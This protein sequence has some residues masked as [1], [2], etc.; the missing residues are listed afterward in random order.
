MRHVQENAVER[1][2]FSASGI[3]IV[4]CSYNVTNVGVTFPCIQRSLLKG[5]L[6]FIIVIMIVCV[7]IKQK[8]K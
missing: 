3:Y 8:T 1:F 5:F 6:C 4:M 2:V 7:Q